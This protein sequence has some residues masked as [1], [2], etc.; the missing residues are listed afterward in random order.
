M[1]STE[2][3]QPLPHPVEEYTARSLTHTV[4]WA[5]YGVYCSIIWGLAPFVMRQHGASAVEA[6]AVHAARAVPVLLAVLWLP[7]VE[8]RNPVRLTGLFLAA[9][10][11]MLLFS[12]LPTSM[13]VLALVLFAAGVVS[14]ASQPVLGISLEQVY[15]RALR[16]KLMS[17]P[18]FAS[19]LAQVVCLFTVGF[20]LQKHPDAYAWAFPAAGASLVA[21][22]I[23]FRRIRG[24]RGVRE[25]FEGSAL[26]RL[27]DSIA[28]TFRNRALFIFLFGY[29][30]ATCGA[31]LAGNV[32]HL[33]ARDT[34]ALT[35]EQYAYARAGF[36]VAALVSFHAWGRFMDRFGAPA[37]M[38]VAWVLQ[39]AAI[40]LVYFADSALS[41]TALLTARGLFQ[42]GNIIA[43]FPIV[44][45]F[46]DSAET[47]RGMSL[48]YLFWGVRWLTMTGLAM[49]IVDLE[50]LSDQHDI[51]LIGGAAVLAGLL[52]MAH[53]WWM[54]GREEE[55]PGS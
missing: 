43:F 39:G 48:H 20:W 24:S 55:S 29:F 47:G 41:F 1:A 51:Y 13:T 16:G 30:V 14:N 5:F 21:A 4:A 36:M 18:N 45:H 49:A 32:E 22:G 12:G 6:L 23:I 44:M 33:F 2:T 17:L 34:L 7:F 37:T 38:V 19:M 31:V 40:S 27:G 26:R 54:D 28:R 42:S 10:G 11:V 35:T 50:L 8:R 53:V 25:S 3:Q 15:P 9:G 52:V 46:T